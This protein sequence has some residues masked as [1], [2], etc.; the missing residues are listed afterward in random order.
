MKTLQ[1]I[2]KAWKEIEHG[3]GGMSRTSEFF[4]EFAKW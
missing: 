2:Q 3:K 4:K 1:S